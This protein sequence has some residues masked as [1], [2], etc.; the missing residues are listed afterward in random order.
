MFIKSLCL[1]FLHSHAS[2]AKFGNSLVRIDDI[3]PQSQFFTS[4]Y[5]LSQS[6]TFLFVYVV[7]SSFND[8]LSDSDSEG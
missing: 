8:S 5:W 7:C 2:A 6:E 1:S 3:L 4:Q